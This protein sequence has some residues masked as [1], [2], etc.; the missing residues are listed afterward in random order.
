VPQHQIS[1][2][3]CPAYLR[4]GDPGR[5]VAVCKKISD[6]SAP[7]NADEQ[8]FNRAVAEITH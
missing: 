5:G 3:F 4:R 8:A 7:S 2:S 6:F 1:V